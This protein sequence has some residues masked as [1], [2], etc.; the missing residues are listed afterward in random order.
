VFLGAVVIYVEKL[1]FSATILTQLVSVGVFAGAV[2]YAELLSRYRDDPVRLL[3]ADPTAMYVAVNVVAGIGALALVKEFSVF[4]SAAAPQAH[5]AT[6][7]ALLAS[8]GAI[9]FFRTSLFTARVGGTDI[10]VGPAT[11]LKSLL[12]SSDFMVNRKQASDRADE[13]QRTMAR[14]DFDKAKSTLPV[15][16]FTLVEGITPDQQKLVAEQIQKLA[17]DTTIEPTAK[18]TILGVYLL[19]QVGADV[20]A[21]AVTVLGDRITS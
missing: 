13:V 3:A 9:A 2:G 17:D 20:L 14:V 10:D 4:G 12:A 19:R 18:A 15:L 16:C 5:Q 1:P 11:L 7:E 21:R 8:F 6:Y